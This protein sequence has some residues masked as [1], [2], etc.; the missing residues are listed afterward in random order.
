M[1][2][3]ELLVMLQKAGITTANTGGLLNTEQSNKF[4]DTVVDQSAFLTSI[5][6]ERNI[7]RARDLD[8]I[9]V[10][11]RLWHGPAEDTE[12]ND[13][14]LKGVTTG[15]RTLTP[16][17]V[18]LPYNISLSYLEENIEK[19]G[20]EN[21]I[22]SI[23]A[24]QFGTD[25]VDALFNCKKA[26]S[27]TDPDYEF[28]KVTDGVIALL[29]ADTDKLMFSRGSGDTDWKG[30][31]F[32][33]VIGML[34]EKYQNDGD[35][36]ILTSL[37]VENEYRDQLGER[38]TVLGD[39]YI[40]EKPTAYFKGLPIKSVPRIPYGFVGVTTL[41]NLAA[42]VGREITVYRQ[43]VPRKRRVEYTITAKLD[44]NYVLTEKISFCN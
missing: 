13:N 42:G 10:G 39:K 19:E 34:P 25:M 31:V 12:P 29:N 6:F 27:N 21:T 23:F 30:S 28:L 8:N 16:V 20:V 1:I 37:R 36:V 14:K 18:M 9:G 35:L 33:G 22:N 32:P 24:K 4:I 38:P 17:E 44:F 3:Q 7:A 5:R 26:T 15:K 41:K 40:M 11:N 2:N 43:L